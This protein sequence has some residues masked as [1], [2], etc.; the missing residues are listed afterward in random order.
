MIEE[1]QA[2]FEQIKGWLNLA[3]IKSFNECLAAIL[4]NKNKSSIIEEIIS[5][6]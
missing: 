1:Y 4:P 3:A 6:V 2:S 5:I